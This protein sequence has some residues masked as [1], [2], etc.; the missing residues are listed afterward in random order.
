MTDRP[1]A[2]PQILTDTETHR[3][4]RFDFAPAA[5]TGW[6]VH[7]FD[8]VIVALT[9]CT[10]TLEMPDGTASQV[11]LPPGRTYHRPEGVEHNVINGG[12]APM[13]FLEV[14]FK[15]GLDIERLDGS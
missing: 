9:E 15:D 11:A 3:I 13:A 8:Y 5:E 2:R 4:T 10:M 7:G 6:H 1:E 14:E 12:A